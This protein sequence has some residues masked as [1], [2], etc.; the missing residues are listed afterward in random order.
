MYVIVVY[1]HLNKKNCKIIGT[2]TKD[3]RSF[4]MV[5][6]LGIQIE[7]RLDVIWK[8]GREERIMT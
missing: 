7:G 5:V 1:R 2:C 3:K 8:Y 6:R 4:P